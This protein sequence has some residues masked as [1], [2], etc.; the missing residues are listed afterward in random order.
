M[1]DSDRAKKLA[2]SLFGLQVGGWTGH[3]MINH[4]KSAVVLRATKGEVVAALKVFDPELVIAFGH[5]EQLERIHRELLLKDESH[6][7]L[8]RIIDGG[9][10][11][12][13]NKLFIVMGLVDG[14][15]LDN[16]LD[17][18]PRD[19][20]WPLIGQV[21]AAAKFLENKEIA[22][23][24]IKPSNIAITDDFQT[25]IL[26]DFGVIRPIGGSNITDDGLKRAFIATLRYSSPELLLRDE[27]DDLEGW[28]AV[29]F[30]Q[31]GAVLHDLIMRRPI[32]DHINLFTRLVHAVAFDQPVVEASDVDHR[33]LTLAHNCLQ[34]K[35]ETRL[36][37]LTW[38]DFESRPQVEGTLTVVA[39]RIRQ[40]Q[41]RGSI[42]TSS[43][44]EEQ[45]FLQ[46]KRRA[47]SVAVNRIIELVRQET[48]GSG[49]F[50]PVEIH[51][52]AAQSESSQGFIVRFGPSNSHSVHGTLVFRFVVDLLDDVIDVFKLRC[53]ALWRPTENDS[54]PNLSDSKKVFGGAVD[55]SS[56]APSVKRILLHA[57]EW[58]I[59]RPDP[60]DV[61]EPE[62][63]HWED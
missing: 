39:E 5:D 60:T 8:V 41:A 32:F 6:P 2:D 45:R 22:H 50:P 44:L 1:L 16:V 51:S 10:C 62:C 14:S 36:K 24:D 15:A 46:A 27:L 18:V 49:V 55:D 20:I 35:P 63:I 40:R 12:Q 34:K 29:T 47:T 37:L 48:I 23:R 30:Y 38:D 57:L 31:L 21:A 59:E 56:L 7:N 43:Q 52:E 53:G 4:G 42:P 54:I 26:L 33:L 28:R 13:T 58:V 11:P 17:D 19:R 3:E 25:A 9:E 61:V